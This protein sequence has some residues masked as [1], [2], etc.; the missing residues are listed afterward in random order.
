[1]NYPNKK[2][3]VC[4][5][6]KKQMYPVMVQE[7]DGE[8][9]ILRCIALKCYDCKKTTKVAKDFFVID[10]TTGESIKTKG[11]TKKVA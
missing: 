2:E 7:T 3:A 6:C 1:M 11:K 9:E 5:T 8:T 4:P 10:K